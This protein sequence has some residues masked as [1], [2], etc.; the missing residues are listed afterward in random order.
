MTTVAGGA[1]AVSVTSITPAAVVGKLCESLPP[2]ATVPEK[3]SVVRVTV[4]AVVLAGV[5]LLLPQLEI[6]IR[7][8][9]AARTR[10]TSP[11]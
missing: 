6:V 11:T 7:S 8:N 10:P 5:E 1:A 2:T 9:T 3:V 4:A